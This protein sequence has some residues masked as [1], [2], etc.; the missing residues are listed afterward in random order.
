[1]KRSLRRP[2]ARATLGYTLVEVLVTVAVASIG[3]VA[4][5]DLQTS[6]I[7]GIGNAR[8]MTQGVH[9]AEHLIEEVRAMSNA[10]EPSLSGENCIYIPL[11]PGPGNW[12][13]LG[14]QSN[15]M[16]SPASIDPEDK[17][18]GIS[19]EMPLDFQRHFCIHHR[20]SWLIEN[21][22][23]RLDVRVVWPQAETDM[24][25]F[26]ACALNLLPD[27]PGENLLVGLVT[28]STAIRVNT[29]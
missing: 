23:M 28:L 29:F 19:S 26:K 17:D 25:A 3:F 13:V 22:V 1:M 15:N 11:A 4:I 9:L 2:S 12:T 10:C 20:T 14:D 27:Q 16:V 24:E 21:Q 5:L 18:F 6:S 7:R 8:N